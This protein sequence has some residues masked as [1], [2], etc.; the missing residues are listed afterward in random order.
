MTLESV[1]IYLFHLNH[2]SSLHLYFFLKE[3][4]RPCTMHYNQKNLGWKKWQFSDFRA[5][6]QKFELKEKSLEPSRIKNTSAQAMAQAS[7]AWTH[8]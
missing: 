6:K 7:S 3:T 4:Y 2:F 8:I 1:S 5:K